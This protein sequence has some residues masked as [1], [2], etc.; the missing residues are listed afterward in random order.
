M[1]EEQIHVKKTQLFYES[2]NF[3]LYVSFLAYF[4][5]YLHTDMLQS[6]FYIVIYSINPGPG[7]LELTLT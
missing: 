2:N 1:K 5:S 6:I 4:V 3:V 7:H